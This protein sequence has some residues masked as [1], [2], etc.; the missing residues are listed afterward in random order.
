MSGCIRLDNIQRKKVDFSFS[1]FSQKKLLLFSLPSKTTTTT[2]ERIF[3]VELPLTFNI[4]TIS[5]LEVENKIRWKDDFVNK[6]LSGN[7]CVCVVPSA[8]NSP[9]LSLS[10]SLSLSSK[11][12]I[13]IL[14]VS[15]V[16]S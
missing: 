14:M 8:K 5:L 11:T 1:L 16:R 7:V 4:P 6:V 12:P 9:S 10:L 2:V 3:S 15:V 13:A